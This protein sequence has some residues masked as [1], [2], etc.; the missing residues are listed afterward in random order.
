[1]D[2]KVSSAEDIVRR[3][4]TAEAWFAAIFARSRFGI[5][6]SAMIKMIAT[7]INNSINEK[8]FCFLFILEQ[9]SVCQVGAD[10]AHTSERMEKP[11]DA[12]NT[13]AKMT[14]NWLTNQV[15]R[16]LL[17]WFKNENWMFHFCIL[18]S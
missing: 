16:G 12:R 6:I 7:T 5:A 9:I 3:E 11:I 14:A 8:P 18:N 13:R 2:E 17:R 1:V 4:P 15:D 10:E